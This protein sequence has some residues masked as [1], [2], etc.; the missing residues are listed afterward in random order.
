MIMDS[1][2]STALGTSSPINGSE[3]SFA[4]MRDGGDGTGPMVLRLVNHVAHPQTVTVRFTA[5]ASGG[6]FKLRASGG[7]AKVLTL[8]DS[9]AGAAGNG[10]NSP[11]SPDRI[12]PVSS[13]VPVPVDGGTVVLELPPYSYVNAVLG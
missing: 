6:A 9:V 13:T 2:A 11:A 7:T 8:Q 4:A 3:L 5:K 10:D 12:A 1:W